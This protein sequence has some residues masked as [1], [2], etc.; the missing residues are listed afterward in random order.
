MSSLF[1][2]KPYL[3]RYKKTLLIGFITIICSNLFNVS[4]PFLLGKA[5]DELKY[6][7]ETKTIVTTDLIFFAGLIVLFAFIAGIFMFFT[8]QT[9]IV[10]SRHIEY[11]LRNDF[12]DHLQK[13]SHS[14]YQN[15]P[16]GDIMAHATNDINSVRNVLG[17]GL[18]YPL[19]TIITLICVL[20]MMFLTEWQLTLLALIPMPFITSIVYMFGKKIN[21][22]FTERQELFS[23]L[24]IKAHEIL[25]A[26]RIIKTFVREAYEEKKFY[27][28]SH[29]YL[30]KNLVLAKIHS[31]I[32][33]LLFVLV[34]ISLIITLYFGGYR[35]IENKMT[36][37]TLTAFITYLS[38]LI[39]P[40]IAFG[41]VIN[42]WQQGAASMNRLMSIFNTK[43]DILDTEQTDYSIKNIEGTIEFRNVSFHHKNSD[44]LILNNIN[45][46]I[47]KGTTLAVVGHT[48]SGKTTFA[49]LIPRIFDTTEGNIF[50]DGIDIRKIPLNVLRSHIGFVPQ[51]TYLFSDTIA[52]NI[53]YGASECENNSFL[54]SVEIAQL[55]KDVNNFSNK[56]D[57]II[58]E[59]GI[60][61]S[62]GQKQRT[63]LARAILRKP[64]ILILDDALSAVDTETEEM[65]L[66]RLR[67][68]MQGR[69]NI[70]I[71]HRIST[72]KNADQIIVLQNGN[73]TEQGTHEELLSLDGIYA[74]LY[75]KQLLEEQLDKM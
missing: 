13:L 40:M 49:S 61:L 31:L 71:S 21:Q 55:S 23:K 24:T 35:I 28:L 17:P 58:G 52:E 39:W 6:G 22:K 37:G 44:R 7:L 62:G 3:F 57:T 72:V 38:M 9:I 33:P 16:T 73:I 4:L 54:M 43:P 63:S 68:F 51:E 46:K 74:N 69:T 2:L 48:G 59:R 53:A 56:F 11:D 20:S 5:I 41:W 60:T 32:W 75:K 1:Y 67:T 29:N 15:T 30:K 8:R 12:L 50:I 18:M 64:A 34:G 70:I 45:I 65:I 27:E 66:R 47:P 36:I 14:Y 19:D 10:V 25:S 42:I 26:I